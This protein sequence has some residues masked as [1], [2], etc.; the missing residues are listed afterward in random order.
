MLEPST[1]IAAILEKPGAGWSLEDAISV[2]EW[3]NDKPQLTMLRLFALHHLGANASWADAED[4]WSDFVAD[5]ELERTLMKFEPVKGTF[6]A[7]LLLRFK[8][9][10]WRRAEKLRRTSELGVACEERGT[11]AVNIVYSRTPFDDVNRQEISRALINCLNQLPAQLGTVVA[12]Y[13]QFE[14]AV[15]TIADQLEISQALVKV[16]LWRARGQ[17]R[18][19]M[20]SKGFKP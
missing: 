3:L 7:W 2:V 11:D 8:Q 9:L 17:L 13:Y 19:C 6:P 10:C 4:A 18:T 16:R 1:E 20:K 15:A 12:L 14:R 5:K